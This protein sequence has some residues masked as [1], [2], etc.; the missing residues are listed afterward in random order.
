LAAN[1]RA[2]DL[3]LLPSGSSSLSSCTA[4]F[5]W[6]LSGCFPATAGSF[7][8]LHTHLINFEDCCDFEVVRWICS[9]K[10]CLSVELCLILTLACL[11]N[12]G[13]S[14][15]MFFWFRISFSWLNVNYYVIFSESELRASVLIHL[16]FW[17]W[18][19]LNLNVHHLVYFDR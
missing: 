11:N 19:L 16:T 3:I 13:N 10:G 9:F 12:S 18:P 8:F 2:R 5:S 15:S 7:E 4:F 6:D 14:C 17:T 1:P